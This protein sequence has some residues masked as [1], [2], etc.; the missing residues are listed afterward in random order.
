MNQVIILTLSAGVT[1][2]I[3][4]L[5][6]LGLASK[7][8][9]FITVSCLSFLY[10]I[11]YGIFSLVSPILMEH[12]SKKKGA[13]IQQAVKW[14]KQ[15]KKVVMLDTARRY[16]WNVEEDKLTLEEASESK[17]GIYTGTA[18]NYYQLFHS[19]NDKDIKT[20]D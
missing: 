1:F 9:F 5:L 17:W 14:M 11:F 12:L 8:P 3:V 20:K 7:Q 10:V 6:F 13:T 18:C 4:A 16:P 15:G 19:V 2:L